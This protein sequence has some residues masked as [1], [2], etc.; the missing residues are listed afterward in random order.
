[1]TIEP[2]T[3]EH[4][5]APAAVEPSKGA[6]AAPAAVGP[7][8]AAAP[9]AVPSFMTTAVVDDDSDDD[10]DVPGAAAVVDASVPTDDDIFEVLK[11]LVNRIPD[12]QAV[13]LKQLR[14]RAADK[15]GLGA[16]GLEDRKARVSELAASI[17][18]GGVNPNLDVPVFDAVTR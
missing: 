10:A 13:T 16:D 18:D 12:L 14:E 5:A 4:G 17:I 2:M 8:V 3:D 15:L 1:M 11:D 9:V 6:A 7:S